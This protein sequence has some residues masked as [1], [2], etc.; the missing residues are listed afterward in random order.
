MITL[1]PSEQA[2]VTHINSSG[3]RYNA[4]CAVASATIIADEKTLTQDEIASTIWSLKSKGVIEYT[5]VQDELLYVFH[6]KL[7]Q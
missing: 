3:E 5:W 4:I 6:S 2:V 1:T 7:A